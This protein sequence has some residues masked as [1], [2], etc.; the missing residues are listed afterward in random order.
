[1]ANQQ[2]D[3]TVLVCDVD[4]KNIRPQADPDARLSGVVLVLCQRDA[5]SHRAK[6]REMLTLT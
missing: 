4:K 3:R 1:M 5:A 2:R 6:P